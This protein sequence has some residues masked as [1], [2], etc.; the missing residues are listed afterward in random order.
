V[1]ALLARVCD[2]TQRLL[3][4]DDASYSTHLFGYAQDV[5]LDAAALVAFRRK[6]A[7][8]LHPDVIVLP[9]CEVVSAWL[10][11]HSELRQ[12]MAARMR[13]VAPLRTMLAD[14]GLRATLVGLVLAL[15]SAFPASPLALALPSPRKWVGDAYRAAFV[16]HAAV[17]V[18]A[19]ESDA[20]AVY[21]AEFMR[22]FGETGIDSVLLVES[23]DAEPASAV[24]IGWYRPVI[25][26]AGHYRWDL[27]VHLPVAGGFEGDMSGVDYIIAPR[28]LA[29]VP[30]GIVTQPGFWLGADA[31]AA[32]KG[33]FR[34]ACIPARSNP[35]RV[36]ERLAVLRSG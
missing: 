21:V 31:P 10:Q 8:L 22:S 7:A 6:A 4:L 13:T 29:G 16:E 20:A 24:E 19:E 30:T 35:E 27:G 28:V 18:G 15:R 26:L 23:A 3:W 34:F 17:S 33:G 32:A 11:M 5:W 9:L 25:N 2:T 1:A 14:E 12:S 36:L